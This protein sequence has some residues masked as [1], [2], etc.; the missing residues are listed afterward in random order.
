MTHD[1]ELSEALLSRLNALHRACPGCHGDLSAEPDDRMRTGLAWFCPNPDCTEKGGCW[2][3]VEG[4]VGR[5][6]F[7]GLTLFMNTPTMQET[8]A[9]IVRENLKRNPQ[10]AAHVGKEVSLEEFALAVV[11]QYQARTAGGGSIL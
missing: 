9:G 10:L 6:W 7:G 8:V 11:I 3:V 2:P 1:P 4:D 5:A